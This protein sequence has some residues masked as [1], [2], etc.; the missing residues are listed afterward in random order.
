[1]EVEILF[2]SL[3]EFQAFQREADLRDSGAEVADSALDFGLLR[4]HAEQAGGFFL[5][6]LV[7]GFRKSGPE[8]PLAS[9]SFADDRGRGRR[10]RRQFRVS[11]E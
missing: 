4:L 8:A 9:R 11:E 6:L 1:M 3:R 2:F 5:P 7:R 10:P